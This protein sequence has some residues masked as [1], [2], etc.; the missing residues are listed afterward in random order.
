MFSQGYSARKLISSRGN[1]NVVDETKFVSRLPERVA[2]ADQ[3]SWEALKYDG[4]MQVRVFDGDFSEKNLKNFEKKFERNE[5][6]TYY[7]VEPT[8]NL[9][10]IF[11]HRKTTPLPE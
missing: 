10:L 2:T 3:R 7:A 5:Y 1:Q 4:K 8:F 9:F 11:G 6:P